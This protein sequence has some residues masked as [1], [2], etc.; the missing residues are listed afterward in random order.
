MIILRTT[1]AKKAR[2]AKNK[3]L[4]YVPVRKVS[5]SSLLTRRTKTRQD[6]IN[7]SIT[8]H[9]LKNYDAC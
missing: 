2:K 4:G 1:K 9:K 7:K 5:D 8:K 3:E 6:R